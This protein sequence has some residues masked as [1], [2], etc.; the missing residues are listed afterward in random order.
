M[1]MQNYFSKL[2]VAHLKCTEHTNGNKSAFSEKATLCIKVC[3]QVFEGCAILLFLGMYISCAQNSEFAL[4][5]ASNCLPHLVGKKE[6]AEYLYATT[7]KKIYAIGNQEGKFP[8]V[9]FH[10]KGEMGGV[11]QHTIKLMDGYGFDI[12]PVKSNDALQPR[13][14]EFIA[15][16][17]VTKFKYGFNLKD[18]KV[19]QTQFIPDNFPVA[20]VEYKLENTGRETNE[21]DFRFH[22]DAN[23]MP[24]WL[25]ERT[26]MID[27]QDKVYSHDENSL[28]T[29]FKDEGSNWFSGVRFEKAKI[30]FSRTEKTAYQGKGISQLSAFRCELKP[31][32]PVYLRC[33]I[34]GYMK[35]AKEAEENMAAVQ[36]QVR[37]LFEEKKKRY[38]NIEQTAALSIPDKSIETA[39]LWGKFSTDW[40]KRDFPLLGKGLSAG[41]PDYPWYFSNDQASAFS[42]L[43]GTMEPQLFYQVMRMFRHIS[44]TSN[45]GLGGVIH[46]IS[47][48]GAI[49]AK[50]RMS[51]SQQ[52]ISCAW[53]IYK[54]TGDISFLKENYEYGKRI[55]TWLQQ[56]DKD[57][58]GYFEGYGG[59]EIEGLNDE[60]FDVQIGTVGF[61]EIL[62]QMATALNETQPAQVFAKR[63]NELKRKIEKDWWIDEECRYA[64]FIC[65]KQ[66]AIQLINEAIKNRVK[67]N[68]NK[69]ALAK[70]NKLKNE[71]ASNQY[72]HHGYV[73]YYNPGGL[74]PLV[75]GMVDAARAKRMLERAAYFTNKF[76]EY[77]TGIERPDNLAMDEG[78]FKKDTSFT[79]NRAVMPVATAGLAIAAAKYG[80][81]DISLLYIRKI[82]NSFGYATP[83]TIYE[84]SPDY[85]MFVQAWNVA[86]INIPVI[87]YFFGVNPD[88]HNKRI[89]INLQMPDGW[90]KASLKNLLIGDNQVSFYYEKSGNK[91]TYA[92]E[93]IKADWS[94]H[95]ALNRPYK[96]ITVNGKDIPHSEKTL[97]LTGGRNRVVFEWQ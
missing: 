90:D 22:A 70:L 5:E 14:D 36:R 66:K 55:W 33:F 77:I 25:G 11:W 75:M 95:L 8:A 9:G 1:L 72:S 79:Y 82:L 59:V 47:S 86:G 37:Q 71:I 78:S 20:V 74:E 67:P 45:H 64:D 12:K 3:R 52:Q 19:T 60:M 28:T 51:E 94:F 97:T 24:V 2:L 15:Y 76:G 62:S 87:R 42:A 17:F 4:D 13:C 6:N 85:G 46:E 44:D 63:A 7:G 18:I 88:A 10:V 81:T 38:E 57:R 50:G 69:W 54:W 91:A 23:L 26:G 92:I 43:V 84:V 49:F 68:R 65:S 73:V 48:N 80:M 16:S 32:K 29:I 34:S 27:R 89:D 96:N 21:Y 61:L 83:G 56:H 53:D 40:L 93:S 41:L 39:Y 30:V 35:S 31:N 58:N